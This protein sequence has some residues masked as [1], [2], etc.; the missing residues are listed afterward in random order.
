MN[1]WSQEIRF[2]SKLVCHCA[3]IIVLVIVVN[4]QSLWWWF[5]HTQT[6]FRLFK[7]KSIIAV[8]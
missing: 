4:E 8:S 1:E 7:Y 3:V 6:H 2:M 5:W